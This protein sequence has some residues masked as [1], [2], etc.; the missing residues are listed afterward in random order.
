MVMIPF[1]VGN[2][3]TSEVP[4]NTIHFARMLMFGM[5][6]TLICL[7]KPSFYARDQALTS[8]LFA[9][10]DHS[11]DPGPSRWHAARNPLPKMA[12]AGVMSELLQRQDSAH[13]L[14]IL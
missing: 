8:F 7:S 10:T 4:S 12:S 2:Q 1:I 13:D 11:G 9:V 3:Q 6:G 14:H 5:A